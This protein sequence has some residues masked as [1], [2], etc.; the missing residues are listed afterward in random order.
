MTPDPRVTPA[1]GRVADIALRGVI[2]ADRYVKP[3]PVRIA[4][5]VADLCDRPG[6]KRLRQLLLGHEVRVYED[7]D[8]WSFL[9]GEDGYVGY[10]ASSALGIRGVPTHRVASFATHVYSA[11]DMKSPVRMALPFG[12][13]VTAQAIRGTMIE[14]PDGFVPRGH[15][16]RLD[17]PFDDPVGVAEIHLR[18][19]YLWGGNSTRGIDCSGLV[20]AAFTACG[21]E[22]PGDSDMQRNGLGAALDDHAR[23]RRGDLVFW[24]GH[25]GLMQDEGFLL[26]ANA[27]AMATTTE[28]LAVAMRRIEKAGGGRVLVRRR[29]LTA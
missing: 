28:P 24:T 29:V 4:R 10:V 20:Q 18:V 26:H 15:L 1:N 8:G 23:L 7:R 6:G 3:S 27:H 21:I 22:C 14:T 16:R 11:A 9:M 25:V 17:R 13:R 2:A 5:P 19:P 12:A